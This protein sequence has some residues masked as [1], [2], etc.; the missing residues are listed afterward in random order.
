MFFGQTPYG[1]ATPDLAAAILGAAPIPPTRLDLHLPPSLDGP[2]LRALDRDSGRRFES[3]RTFV[4]YLGAGLIPQPEAPVKRR[5]HAGWWVAAAALPVVAVAGYL[6][7]HRAPAAPVQREQSKAPLPP[8]PDTGHARRVEIAK[9]LEVGKI[10][11]IALKA[12]FRFQ[13]GRVRLVTLFGGGGRQRFDGLRGGRLT[14][15]GLHDVVET[16]PGEATIRCWFRR[17]P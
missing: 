5:S 2:V 6:A 7:I 12:D 4:G 14:G 17:D 9:G 16:L 8:V 10:P 13:S 15:F 1:K 11:E 3:C